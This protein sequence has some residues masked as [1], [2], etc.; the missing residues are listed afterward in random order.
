MRTLNHETSIVIQDI[1]KITTHKV[2]IE[3]GQL[4]PF[5]SQNEAFR[6]Y[7]R[8]TVERWIKEGLV[9]LIKDGDKN[10]DKRIDRVQIESVAHTSNRASWYE[11]HCKD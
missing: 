3:T 8:T 9:K 7:G 2:L 5:I 1:V 4:K 10:C 11:N 6:R